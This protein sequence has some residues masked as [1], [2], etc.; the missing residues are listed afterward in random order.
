[1]TFYNRNGIL[2]A[3]INGKRIS[4]KLEYSKDNIKLFKSYAKN[5]EFFKKFDVNQTIQKTQITVIEICQ[6]ILEEKKKTLKANTYK[7][8]FSLFNS[9]IIPFFQDK[10]VIDIKPIHILE[11]YKTFKDKASI[12][13]CEA[14]LKPAFE[15]A[16][17]L[18]LIQTT[19]FIVKKPKIKSSDYEI[20]PFTLEELQK[21]ID[22]NHPIIGNF[23]AIACLTG[24]RTGELCG[25]RWCDVDLK[26]MKISVNQQFTNGL[27]QSPKTKK[28]KGTIDL[29]IEALP[30][31]EKQKL[32][33]G[34]KEYIFYST[35]NQELRYSLSYVKLFKAMLKELNI[36]IR[37]IYQTRH[38]FASIR[39][40]L[41][42]RIEWV[43]YMMRHKNINIT[44]SKYYKYI[45]ELDTKRVKLNLDLTQNRHTN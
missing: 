37:S 15:K 39:L 3:R 31:F 7:S 29:P 20:N 12:I 45:K 27:L 23:V 44:L 24:L 25:L 34:M 30:F 5:D 2:Y 36:E 21:I 42:E 1:M 6:E 38:T 26:N 16:I 40:S 41:G 43:S 33:T 9:K 17:L 35:K 11:F 19:P 13:T 10:K 8:Y 14:I 32:K 22:Y 28:S 4:T 18:E